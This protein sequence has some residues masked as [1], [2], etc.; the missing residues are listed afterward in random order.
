MEF[1]KIYTCIKATVVLRRDRLVQFSSSFVG[2]CFQ[3]NNF[4][5]LSRIVNRTYLKSM[6][7]NIRKFENRIEIAFLV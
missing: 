1:G 3:I 2:F 5:T 7:Q 6:I 4:F